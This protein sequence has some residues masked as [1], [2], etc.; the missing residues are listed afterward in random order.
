MTVRR[1]FTE[2]APS[3]KPVSRSLVVTDQW[4][5]IV[6]APEYDVPVVGFGTARRIAPGVAEI[7]SPLLVNNTGSQSANVSVRLVRRLQP[8]IVSQTQ[9][10]YVSRF[11][12][13]EQY[14]INDVITLSNGAEILVVNTDAG[15][16][17]EFEVVG[18][19]DP[20]A[21]DTELDQINN[22]GAGTG[23]SLLTDAANL[24]PQTFSFSTDFPVEIR[25]TVIVPLNGQF[26]Q[27][28]DRLEVISN[29]DSV[30]NA[31][32]SFTEG[33]AEEDDIFTD[34]PGI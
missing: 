18:I 7:S 11:A 25:N 21:A 13:G 20:V 15:T 17:T 31:T 12:G 29:V 30:L 3:A 26:L 19:G 9:S 10:D 5:T 22:T 6:D 32:I 4:Q 16:V 23:F 27:S 24:V 2:Q 14:E 34:L 1:I 8:M 33:Q 28:G